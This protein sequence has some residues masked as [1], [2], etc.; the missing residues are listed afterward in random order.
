MAVTRIERKS[1]LQI[2]VNIGTSQSPKYKNITI[3]NYTMDPDVQ[4]AK[5]YQCASKFAACQTHDLNTVYTQEK[6]TLIS[7]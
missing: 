7:E 5:R 6:C 3:L 1:N 2:N 4:L